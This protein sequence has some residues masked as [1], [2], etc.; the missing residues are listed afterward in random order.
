MEKIKILHY[1]TEQEPFVVVDKPSGL[2]SAPLTYDD[3]N[4]VVH[5]ISR[6]FPAV[7]R[8]LIAEQLPD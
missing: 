3:G 8:P 6:H 4:N 2:P 7:L 5:L 1:P